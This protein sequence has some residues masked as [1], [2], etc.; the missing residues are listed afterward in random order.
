[1]RITTDH[2][3]SSY[4]IPVILDDAGNVM[5]YAPGIKAVRN[6]LGFSTDL[7]GEAVGKS[8]RTVEGWE[9]G[10][11]MPPTESLYVL[12]GLLAQPAARP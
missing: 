5:D 6:R 11:R 1:M 9:Q 8:G 10:R 12:A 7:L 3:T 4:G 2:P